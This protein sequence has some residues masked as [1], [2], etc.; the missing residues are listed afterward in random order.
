MTYF[1]GGNLKIVIWSNQ[2]FS[3]GIESKKIWR[4]KLSSVPRSGDNVQ[5]KEVAETVISVDWILSK[6]E[7]H[8]NIRPDYANYY[9]EIK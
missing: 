7:A 8:L 5:I 1:K 3:K 6:N 9:E 2:D 4:G